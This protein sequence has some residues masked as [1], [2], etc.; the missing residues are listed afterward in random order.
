[1]DVIL[2]RKETIKGQTT[3]IDL[4]VTLPDD[5]KWNDE[6]MNEMKTKKFRKNNKKSSESRELGNEIFAANNWSDAMECYNES[7]RFAEVGTENVAL[8]YFFRSACFFKLNMIDEAL[9][10][11]ELATK[12]KIP[13]HLLPELEQRKQ[14]CLELVEVV[15]R[16]PEHPPELDY[17]AN[18][19]Y[20]CLVNK[21]DIKCNQQFGRHLIA[22]SDIPKGKTILLE[23]AF[24]VSHIQDSSIC[25]TCY[26]AT[27]SNFLA[28]EQCTNVVYCS[29]ECKKRNK[30]HEWECGTFFGMR[31]FNDVEKQ[32][33]LHRTRLI[34]QTVLTAISTFR[35][36]EA[37]MR[38]VE[39]LV[40]GDGGDPDKLPTSLDDQFS[41]YHFFFKLKKRMRRKPLSDLKRVYTCIL[42]LPKIRDMFDT[43]EKKRFLMHL[44]VCHTIIVDSNVMEFEEGLTVR[45]VF[46]MFNHC[47]PNVK[48]N[49]SGKLTYCTTTRP[50][51]KG[52]QLFINYLSPDE[53]KLPKEKR[54]EQF[55]YN[56]GFE[57][58]CE[59]C[60]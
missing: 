50:V 11:I 4:F 37:L 20:P 55:R 13:D 49:T 35:N 54:Q 26:R 1:M 16:E 36:V 12:E 17:E 8:A 32:K 18:K 41:K 47:E 22:N 39:T 30:T 48:V 59:K 40:R 60:A 19:H 44:V 3:F 14:E 42:F 27:F 2:W 6:S 23:E 5:D 15:R 25:Y 53:M 52:E 57:C 46:S 58:K 33:N 29:L 21:V 43:L 45:N 24:A 38:F 56:W 51:K 10:D 31:C 7:L 28:C 9:A 34:I